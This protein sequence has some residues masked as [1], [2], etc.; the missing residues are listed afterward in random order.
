M[1]VQERIFW[2]SPEVGLLTKCHW[3]SSPSQHPTVLMVH[4]LEG[5][6]ESHYMR[7][8][9]QKAWEAG[10]NSIRINQRNCGGSLHLSPT[11]YHN[12]LSQDFLAVIHQVTEWYGCRHVWLV[13]YSMG[14]NLSLKL[15]G[16]IGSSLPSLQ[17]VIAV[18]PNIEPA[19]CVRALQ[20]PSNWMYHRY[21]L[22][23]LKATLRKKAQLY[24]GA[25]DLSPLDRILTLREFDEIYTAPDGGFRDA[26]DYYEQTA[27]RNVLSSIG[28]PTLIMTSRDDPFIP[29]EM[30][31]NHGLISNPWIHLMAPVYGGHC[32]FLQ[33]HL[34][35][36]D[37]FWAE[38]RIIEFIKFHEESDFNMISTPP[39]LQQVTI[40]Q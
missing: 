39:N 10:W 9:A 7:G 3:Q 29:Y 30:F 14:G 34:T 4:G 33:R 23:S 5:C 13:G 8:L 21:F 32:G 18:C 24:P 36:E 27:A 31:E 40:K 37:V 19:A 1:P 22:N 11:L 16:E 35:H 12:G 17:G 38:N 6:T 15:A 2:V 25:W 28:I 26:A 20:R